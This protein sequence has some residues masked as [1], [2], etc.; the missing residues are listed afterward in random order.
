MSELLQMSNKELTRLEVIQRL[1]QK[2]LKQHEAA[3]MLGL[4]V[5]KIKRL[6]RVY[7]QAGAAGLISR[8]RG[9]PGNNRLAA[10]VKQQALELLHSRYPDFGPTLAH[11]KLTEN[12]QLKLSVETVRQ[13]MIAEGLWQPRHARHSAAH[14]LR[15]RR[16]CLGELVQ[17][18][19]SPHDWFEGRAPKCTLLVFIDDATGRLMVLHFTP[20]ETTFSYFQAGRQYLTQHGKPMAFYSDKHSIFRVNQPGALSGSGLTQFSRAMYDLD[21]QVIC[22]NTP[23]A[24]GRVERANQ[25]L[26]DRLV[27]EMRLREIDGIRAGNAYLPTFLADFNTRFA[28][29]PRSQHNAH[30][31]LLSAD[32]LDLI[33]TQ[34]ATR[35]LSKNLSFQYNK[36][37]YQIETTRPGYALRNAQITVCEH[38]DGQITALYKGRPLTYT[39]YRRQP[40]QA[41]VASSKTINHKL[42]TPHRPADNHPWR[43]YGQRIN[44]RPVSQETS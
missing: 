21:I 33:L 22:A 31:P 1:E 10:A 18:D 36:V 19:G 4:S 29:L 35:T 24:K 40:L 9:R 16:A 30:R 26:Q 23:Q 34:Q 14:Q 25:T 27:K 8:R 28:V 32:N 17:I 7:R 44:G 41:E 38:P 11:E 37:L 12:H 43:Q 3:Q 5:R 20:A 42:S 15:E 13:L 39:I 2:T 6:W